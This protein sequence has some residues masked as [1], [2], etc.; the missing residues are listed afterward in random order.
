MARP[1]TFPPGHPLASQYLRRKYGD[2]APEPAQIDFK[3]IFFQ[4]FV[5]P[6]GMKINPAAASMEI[7]IYVLG[8]YIDNA[9]PL[10]NLAASGVPLLV[11]ISVWPDAAAQL[12]ANARELE[13]K[14]GS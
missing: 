11:E 13:E 5:S 10:R 2:D 4:A 14:Y 6:S 8:Q 9:L 1:P 7:P 3:P 12:E